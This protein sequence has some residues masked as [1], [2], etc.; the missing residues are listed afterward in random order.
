[1]KYKVG[2]TISLIQ[3]SRRF[4]RSGAKIRRRKPTR[5]RQNSEVQKYRPVRHRRQT[6]S[7]HEKG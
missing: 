6:E 3:Q 5:F 4:K 7:E 1:M 2:K